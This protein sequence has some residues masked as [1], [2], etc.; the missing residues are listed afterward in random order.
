MTPRDLPSFAA[1]WPYYLAEH[2]LPICRAWHYFGTLMAT[3]LTIYCLSTAAYAQLAWVLL[4]GYGPA[5][6]G[7]FIFEKNRPATFIYPRWSLMADYKMCWYW[8]SGQLDE[9]LRRHSHIIFR[10]PTTAT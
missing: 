9:E 4:A 5:W 3:S 8:L 10:S 2:R 7:H 1:F 6:I